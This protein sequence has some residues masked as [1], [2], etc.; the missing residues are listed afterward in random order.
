MFNFFLFLNSGSCF[1]LCC[2]LLLFVVAA[3]C[4]GNQV[5]QQCGTAC[6]PTCE[7]PNPAICTRQC[8]VGCFCP[9]GMYR[10]SNGDC[11]TLE[12]CSAV[13]TE[14]PAVTT[15]PPAPGEMLCVCVCVR[16]SVCVCVSVYAWAG[17][18]VVPYWSVIPGPDTVCT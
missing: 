16:A 10:N 3:A 7:N 2:C 12:Q 15:E 11:V 4:T 17:V 6:P 9:H 14:P 13:T 5:F 18:C 1:Y 8:V